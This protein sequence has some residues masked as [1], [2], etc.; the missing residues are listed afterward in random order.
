[1]ELKERFVLVIGLESS[2]KT[3]IYKDPNYHKK[4]RLKNKDRL[5]AW[6]KEKRKTHFDKY[7]EYKLKT[8][9]GIS[10]DDYNKMS[11]QQKGKCKICNEETELVVDHNHETGKVR[12]L[13]CRQCNI[14]LGAIKDNTSF[15]KRA[16]SY[17]ELVPKVSIILPIH[18]MKGGA[19]FLW[20]SINAL[21]QQSYQDFEIII[22]K[23]GLMAENT[24]EG[25]K[26]A[27]GDIIK[28]L[29]LDD[30]LAH[31]DAL[32]DMLE[33]FNG[34]WLICGVD[35]NVYPYWTDDIETG[36][37]KLGSPSALMFKND[38]PLLFDEK[39]SWLLDCDYYKR[40]YER[41]GAPAILNGVHV[42]IGQHE[43][44]VTHLLT[45]SDK[46]SEVNYLIK[47]Y[48]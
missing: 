40:M 10:I 18:D 23:K 14:A 34:T 19:E 22:T 15:L 33:A 4:Y 13:L 32:K 48:E 30:C 44:Q 27:K 9:Y 45:D 37:N 36:N 46:Q 42:L 47:K 26:R 2:M 6:V 31:K 39:M 21:M 35:N 3:G 38:S 41:Y 24:N 7:R 28:I 5:S 20:S 25:I 8:R 12:G 16:I 29:Y 11:E 17:L 1:M 43:G